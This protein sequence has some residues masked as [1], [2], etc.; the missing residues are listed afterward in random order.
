MVDNDKTG[1][2]TSYQ[3]QQTQLRLADRNISPRKAFLSDIDTFLK[4]LTKHP[5][6]QIVL[7]GDLNEVV[8]R[9]PSG[10]A[11]ITSKH[12]LTDIHSHFHSAQ[13]E[14]PT[15]SRGKD[16][17]DFV[18]CSITLLTAV[19][20]C[21][22]EPF[23]QH[24]F[25][26]HRALFVDWNE[27]LLFGSRKSPMLP[28]SQRRL[29]SK[30]IPSRTK[31]IQIL[32]KYCVDHT[33]FQ[34]LDK[35]MSSPSPQK[36]EAIDRDITRGMMAAEARCR[37]LGPDPWSIT[38]QKARLLV[39]IFKHALSML[40][41]GM[42]SRHKLDRLLAKYKDHIDI[43]DGIGDVKQQLTAAQ[44]NL[45][46]VRKEAANHR[47]SMLAENITSAKNQ[48]D[49][50]KQKAAD[51]IA[52][53]EAMKDLHAKLRFISSDGEPNQGLTRVEVPKDPNQDPKTCTDWMV[54]DTPEEIT[55]FLLQ[56]NKNHFGQ[57]QGTPFTISPFNVQVDFGATTE[58]CELM[59]SGDYTTEDADDLTALVVQHFQVVTEMDSLPQSM[60]EKEMLDKYH[61]WPE[62]TMTSPSG[63]HL[64]NYRALLPN[65]PTE[66]S[67]DKE[68]DSKRSMLATMHHSIIDYSLTNG[69]SF[70][71]WQKVVNVM[72]KKDSGNPKIHRLRVIH[73]YEADYNLILGVKWRQLIH[74][75]EDNHLLHPSLYGAR[76]GRGAFE[77]PDRSICVDLFR[78]GFVD[79][80]CGYVNQFC[81]DSPPEPDQLLK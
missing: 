2:Y 5:D 51:R 45:R 55:R 62:S 12:A 42:D 56:R 26:D 49:P 38:L 47:K 76:P 66:T 23:N 34:R 20:A 54:V 60:T 78:V 58:S 18:F 61:A 21:G 32:H 75:C 28:S 8:G 15:Y 29:Q 13:T 79:D 43:P 67:N 69:H 1:P 68:T 73:L 77:S 39:E 7:M 57:A 81:L 11:K 46:Q 17:L 16:R 36:I 14:V 53:A 10:F 9:N 24:I 44:T 64:G 37:M 4:S 74:H 30:S 3:Q 52:K 27:R 72:I 59:L 25:S 31:Y 41:I 40:R 70:R 65:L 22:A 71:R 19:E 50:I 33:I 35:L 80:T 6:S 63:C 48:K